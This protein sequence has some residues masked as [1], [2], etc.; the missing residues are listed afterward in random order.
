MVMSTFSGSTQIDPSRSS[1]E[2]DAFQSPHVPRPPPKARFQ[3]GFTTIE[4]L[5]I[6]AI[7]GILAGVAFIN[8]R[9]LS[10]E[11]Q[12]AANQIAAAVRQVRTKGMAT[13]SAYRLV[14]ESSTTLRASSASNCSV[15]ADSADWVDRPDSDI[16]IDGSGRI[17]AY[18][19]GSPIIGTPTIVCFSSRG[20]STTGASLRV[21]DDRGRVSTVEVFLGGAVEVR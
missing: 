14:F 10:N 5:V 19:D 6:M 16:V 12:N 13:T 7:M 2:S 4:L 20:F 21:L 18:G 11:A 15:D 9:P 8:L 3:L 17:T 1:I